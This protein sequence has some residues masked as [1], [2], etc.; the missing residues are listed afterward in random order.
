MVESS[1]IAIERCKE[2]DEITPEIGYSDIEND[3]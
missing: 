2:F 3:R 1:L